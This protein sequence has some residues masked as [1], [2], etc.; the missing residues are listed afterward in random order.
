MNEKKHSDYFS[1]KNAFITEK[2]ALPVHLS[3]FY[4][5]LFCIQEEAHH[6]LERITVDPGFIDRSGLPMVKAESIS[7][8]E[9]AVGVMRDSLGRIIGIVDDAG[10]DVPVKNILE[11]FNADR[12]FF[13]TCLRLLLN[14][15]A[16]KLQDQAHKLKIG[17]DE[18]IFVLIN[19]MKPFMITLRQ[20][21]M[22][23]SL[24]ADWR[25][26]TCPFCGYLPVIGKIVESQDNR[27]FLLCGLCEHEW[28]FKRLRCVAC[29]SED[30]EKLGFYADV[31]NGMYRFDYCN[32]YGKYI[33]TL[34]IGRGLEDRHYDLTVENLITTFL[35]A[36][37]LEM[38][39]A[40]L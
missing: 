18:F 25:D 34:Q 6:N 32:S 21:N 35:D 33:K 5:S 3:E 36:S 7:I 14:G 12:D 39:Y 8:P 11:K 2:V 19:C 40:G 29:G 26:P 16:Q 23:N 37:A 38:G 24:S 1:E 4:R 28:Q 31:D 22:E 27:R 20:K 13:S 10:I 15:N 9:V 17:Y 30:P